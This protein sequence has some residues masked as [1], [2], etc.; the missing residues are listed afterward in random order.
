MDGL[1]A[2]GG[3]IIRMPERHRLDPDETCM[4]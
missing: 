3:D 2:V 1:K 4:F